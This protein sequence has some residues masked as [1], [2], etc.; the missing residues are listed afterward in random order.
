MAR[1]I[2]NGKKIN[3][4][5][6]V[7]QQLDLNTGVIVIAGDLICH[8]YF[9]EILKIETDRCIIEEIQV[10]MEAHATDKY[11]MV[12]SF[13]SKKVSFKPG[14]VLDSEELRKK[15]VELYGED[16]VWPIEI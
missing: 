9:D 14:E 2:I 15:D 7:K 6:S 16:E 3:G 8:E 13:L 5:V 12:Y 11:Y 1:L 10:T 4:D